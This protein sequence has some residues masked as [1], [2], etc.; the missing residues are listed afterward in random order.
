MFSLQ[1]L[2]KRTFTPSVRSRKPTRAGSLQDL[3]SNTTFAQE[4]G[5]SRSMIPPGCCGPRGFMCRFTIATPVTITLLFLGSTFRTGP[6][7][8]RSLPFT[9]STVSSLLLFCTFLHHFRGQRY[10][11]HELALAQFPGH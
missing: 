2:Q 1:R 6:V 11:L 3:H 5:D 7:R 9:T 4:I 10:D 8:P